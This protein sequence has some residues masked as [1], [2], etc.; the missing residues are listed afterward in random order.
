MQPIQ[1]ERSLPTGSRGRGRGRGESSSAQSHRVSETVDRPETRAPARAYAIRA[2]EDQDKPDVI[3]GKFSIFGKYVYALIDPSFTH[4]YISIPINN[5]KGIQV[6]PLE[7]DIAVTNPLGHLVIVNRVY[8][9]CPICVQGHTFLGD[10]IELP[11]RE[12]DVIL[13]MDWLSRHHVI[14]DCK[15][16]RVTLKTLEGSEVIVVGERSD[17]LSNVISATT[18]RRLIRKGC[19]AY[20]ASVIETKKEGPSGL[21]LPTVCHFSDVFPEELPGL[22]PEREVDFAIEVMPGTTPIS[23]APYRIAPT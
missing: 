10:L 1:T 9:D 7:H 11:F 6:E 12:F 4:S 16:K 23:I 8:R 15:L 5:E 17:Y 14:V 19:T 18:A 20:L 13:G 2:K 22:P 21:N 3:A